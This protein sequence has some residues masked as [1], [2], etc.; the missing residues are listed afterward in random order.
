MSARPSGDDGVVGVLGLGLI[1]GS[2]ARDLAA[3]GRRVLGG[4]RDAAA[5]EAALEA[6]VIEGALVLDAVDLLVL[7]VPVP[8]AVAL[9][10][11]LGEALAGRAVVSDTGSTKRSVMAAAAAA[12]LGDRFVGGHPMAGDHRR[13]WEAGRAGL[14]RGADVWICPGAARV[15]AVAEVAGV[16]QAVGAS[17]RRTDAAAHDRLLARASHLPQAVAS[18]LGAALAGGGV[19]REVLGPGGRDTTRLAASDPDL[20]TG[21]LLDNADEVLEALAGFQ[22]AVAELRRA[23]EERDAAQ[24]AAVLVSGQRW[25]ET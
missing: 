6:G 8:A 14:F 18:A 20:W 9:L 16:W 1:G 22:G 10:P 23:L 4:D 15:E 19:G 5:V 25:A 17:P 12:G 3:A 13:G 2:L 7:A 11:S 24:V 21:I